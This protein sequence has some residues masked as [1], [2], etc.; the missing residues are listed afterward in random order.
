MAFHQHNSLKKPCKEDCVSFHSF[1]GCSH[2]VFAF[3]AVL[4]TVSRQDTLVFVDF[5]FDIL[6][7]SFVVV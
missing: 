1:V 4:E 7:C 6:Q 3:H 5:L 2:C